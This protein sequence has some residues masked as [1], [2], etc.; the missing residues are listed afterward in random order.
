MG[1]LLI[2]MQKVLFAMNDCDATDMC[3][4]CVDDG[5][6]YCWECCA[7]DSQVHWNAEDLEFTDWAN[8]ESKSHGKVSLKE[9]A[10]HE[11]KSHGGKMSFQDWAKHED[12]SHIRRF[13]TY[14]YHDDDYDYGDSEIPW[15]SEEFGEI[16]H[17]GHIDGASEGKIWRLLHELAKME[18]HCFD[19]VRKQ[20]LIE[21]LGPHY[22]GAEARVSDLGEDED[23]L[24]VGTKVRSYDFWTSQGKDSSYIEGVIEKIA[25]SPRCSPDCMHYHIR[26]TKTVRQGKEV[27]EDAIGEIFMTHP[28]ENFGWTLKRAKHIQVMRRRC[29]RN[30]V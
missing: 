21:K 23:L 14:R 12:K 28:Y 19:F 7:R 17:G 18:K 20:G 16:L 1:H 24:P 30:M 2:W 9:W 22:Q 13:G 5:H 11:I 3:E 4:Q 8:Q 10:D 29:R 25:P 15:W 26:T 27:K 6:F